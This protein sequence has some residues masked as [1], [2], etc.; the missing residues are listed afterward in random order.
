MSTKFGDIELIDGLYTYW[1]YDWSI[2][3]LWKGPE[4]YYLGTD[5]GCSCNS[6]W[7]YYDD[8]YDLTGPLTAEQAREEIESLVTSTGGY[9][10]PTA[11]DLND[12]L[13]MVK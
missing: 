1:D 5:S 6:A 11:E 7:E 12:F 3:G 10:E 9:L 4:G 8:P 2:V 13:A